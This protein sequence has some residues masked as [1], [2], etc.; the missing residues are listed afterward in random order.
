MGWCCEYAQ[1]NPRFISN[2]C[3][4]N[5]SF[6]IYTDK[7]PFQEIRHWEGS[8]WMGAGEPCASALLW[9]LQPLHLTNAYWA[10]GRA[11]SCTH[12][13]YTTYTGPSR[14]VPYCSIS[15]WKCKTKNILT[16]ER[17]NWKSSLPSRSLF[18]DKFPLKCQ[19]HIHLLAFQHV[20]YQ[21]LLLR[22]PYTKV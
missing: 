11:R 5:S 4:N 10:P 6:W 13:G 15:V 17:L 19:A 18:Q 1:G 9:W 20:P 16:S 21:N 7:K 22:E 12:S 2:I 8:T 14:I 3:N